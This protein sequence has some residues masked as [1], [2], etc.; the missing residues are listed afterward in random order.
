MNGHLMDVC[1]HNRV[2]LEIVDPA[3][4]TAVQPGAGYMP[5][6]GDER[7]CTRKKGEV[8]GVFTIATEA[9]FHFKGEAWKCTCTHAAQAPAQAGSLGMQPRH[10]RTCASTAVSALS[11]ADGAHA[12]GNEGGEGRVQGP[13]LGQ[14]DILWR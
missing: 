3:A 8:S 9:I 6:P 13:Q 7:Y 12:G 5:I 1:R 2:L 10:A 4:A 14:G 11:H